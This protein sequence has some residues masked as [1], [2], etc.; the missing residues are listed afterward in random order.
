MTH[1]LSFAHEP[2]FHTPPI[3]LYKSLYSNNLYDFII[4]ILFSDIRAICTEFFIDTHVQGFFFCT[5]R[6]QRYSVEIIGLILF[7]HQILKW[8][9]FRITQTQQYHRTHLCC[10]FK[11]QT[12]KRFTAMTYCN[13][14]YLWREK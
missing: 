14:F 5:I 3:K 13:L 10:K 8:I 6:Y 9:P 7:V 12:G 11:P 4:N 2:L 1:S